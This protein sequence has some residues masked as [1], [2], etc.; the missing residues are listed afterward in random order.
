MLEH[1]GAPAELGRS[2]QRFI[3][4][5]R[6]NKL[7][8]AKARTFNLLYDDPALVAPD[9][10]RFDLA[11]EYQAELSLQD[12]DMVSKSLPAGL[13]AKLRHTGSDDRLAQA[14]DYLY[15][16][17]LAQS[18]YQLRDFPLTLERISFFPDVAEYDAITDIYLPLA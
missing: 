18:G 6:A 16:Q 15:R 17:W 9:D 14:V 5:R 4:W 2:I 10:Y 13:W 3:S 11:C 7:P 8:P 12:S 1:H